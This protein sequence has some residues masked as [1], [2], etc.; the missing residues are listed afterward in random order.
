MDH[1]V[2]RSG[3]VGRVGQPRSA[4]RSG[5]LGLDTLRQ[6]V[7]GPARQCQFVIIKQPLG[8]P[9]QGHHGRCTRR[10]SP[11]VAILR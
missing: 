4:E 9:A 2:R 3:H 5:S 8:N 1:P 10:S 6:T 11:P 7:V